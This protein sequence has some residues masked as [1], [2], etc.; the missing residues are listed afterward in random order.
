MQKDDILHLGNKLKS[1]HIHW[2]N[3]KMEVAV[4]AQTL[5]NSV[6]CSMGYLQLIG[7]PK[8]QN[9]SETSQFIKYISNIFDIL[10]SK[11]KFGRHLKSPITLENIDGLEEYLNYFND[12]L[13]KLEDK[14]GVKLVHGPRKTFILGF[15]VLS[16]SIIAIA[17]KLL[18]R[19]GN[20]YD[21]V[22]T[23]CFSQYQIDVF[24]ATSKVD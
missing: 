17:R 7:I 9:S 24:L 1:K 2:H 5:S 18:E 8:F 4:A 10:N 3:V 11:S 6:A 22:L 16:K 21:Y 19:N 12:Y 15:A 13:Q 23:Y 14:D 20:K